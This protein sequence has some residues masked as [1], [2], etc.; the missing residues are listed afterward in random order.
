MSDAVHEWDNARPLMDK[1]PISMNLF[2]TQKGI[3]TA[4]LHD[5]AVSDKKKR[6]P[7]GG[8][9]GRPSI[10]SNHQFKVLCQ[11][12]IWADRANQGLTPAQLQAKMQTLTPGITMKQAQNHQRTFKIRHDGR[13]K[14]KAVRA[15]KTL[16]KRS[17]CTVA[18]QY[19]WFKTVDQAFKFLRENN[20]G[21]CRRTGLTFGEVMEHFIISGDETNLIANPDGEMKTIGEFGRRK[22]EKKVSDCCSSATMFRTGTSGGNNGPMVFVMAGERVQ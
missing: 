20:T 4:T 17:Q 10:L 8:H 15:Q 5:C 9:V 19:R 1:V 22:H 21:L 16:S 2:D 6:K 3:P 14:C 13:L 11:V 7:S 18:H 12:A